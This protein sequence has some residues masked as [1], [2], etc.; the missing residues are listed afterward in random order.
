M[1]LASKG[2]LV[3]G[4]FAYWMREPYAGA[5]YLDGECVGCLGAGCWNSCR[6]LCT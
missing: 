3:S 5:V 2:G 4:G 6:V 1:K